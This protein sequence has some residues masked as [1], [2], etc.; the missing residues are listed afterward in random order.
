MRHDQRVLYSSSVYYQQGDIFNKYM[1][2]SAITLA[3]IVSAEK[4]YGIV[5]TYTRN[6]MTISGATY[7]VEPFIYGAFPFEYT[8]GRSAIMRS[9]AHNID[10]YYR[11]NYLR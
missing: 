11:V 10:Y 1:E 2:A 3:N 5:D 4:N 6:T 8:G 9:L 7:I